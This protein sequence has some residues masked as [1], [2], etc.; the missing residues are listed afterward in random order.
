MESKAAKSIARG[1]TY[2]G[3]FPLQGCAPSSDGRSDP[4]S[5]KNSRPNSKRLR[6]ASLFSR[7][8][9]TLIVLI[10]YTNQRSTEAGRGRATRFSSAVNI[11]VVIDRYC[12]VIR[13]RA[14]STN[15]PPPG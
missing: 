8:D 4:S 6:L 14:G 9:S 15:S 13:D 7:G 11:Q 2:N 12:C 1:E 5:L 10:G 3:N